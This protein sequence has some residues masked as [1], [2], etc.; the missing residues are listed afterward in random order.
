MI[1]SGKCG[2]EPTLI[3]EADGSR[4]VETMFFSNLTGG[5]ISMWCYL[6]PAG[7]QPGEGNCILCNQALPGRKTLVFGEGG[8]ELKLENGDRIFG[9][10]S[11]ADAMTLTVNHVNTECAER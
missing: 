5:E 10:C 3:V 4:T 8:E 7:K 11:V 2:T 9:K 6:V 1:H